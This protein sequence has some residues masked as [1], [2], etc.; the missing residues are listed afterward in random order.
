MDKSI[1]SDK[2][3]NEVNE[4]Q[5]GVIDNN[6]EKIETL[7][8]IEEA[9]TLLEKSERQVEQNE[10]VTIPEVD[11]TGTKQAPLK[12]EDL[13]FMYYGLQKESIENIIEECKDVSK[14]Y[15]TKVINNKCIVAHVIELKKQRRDL[16][17]KKEFKE[18]WIHES[19]NAK[20]VIDGY[21]IKKCE[22][23]K[24]DKKCLNY[25][26]SKDRRRELTYSNSGWNYYPIKCKNVK[27]TSDSCVYSH[28]EYEEDFHVLKY[29]T[30]EC[31]KCDK[32]PEEKLICWRAHDERELRD[33]KELYFNTNDHNKINESKDFEIDLDTYKTEECEGDCEDIYTC[34][35]YHNELERRR[36]PCFDYVAEMCKKVYVEDEFLD[37][38]K[39][40]KHNACRFCHTKN[41][42]YYHK[43]M[44][45]K[46][47]CT[48]KP[49]KYGADNCPDIHEIGEEHNVEILY[50]KKQRLRVS[51]YK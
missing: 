31:T 39:C 3:K 44:F 12:I 50:M 45:R 42:L 21:K 33:L 40:T 15:I 51:F 48:R 2:K 19:E 14:N 35:Y 24:C 41:E 37:P 46:K 6:E 28:S 29:K 47:K 5:K 27:C 11:L 22:K 1:E 34:P 16:M 30:E 25:H 7:N 36:P 9:L 26:S 38:I 10:S 13:A 32:Q 4:E 20:A 18:R 17:T 49:C 43:E 23:E 8:K